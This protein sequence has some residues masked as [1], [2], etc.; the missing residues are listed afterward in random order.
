MAAMRKLHRSVEWNGQS[1]AW[2]G[3]VPKRE[4]GSQLCCG[5]FL[6]S[7]VSGATRSIP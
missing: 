4:Y 2:A 1:P 6:R 5:S 3:Q 7:A